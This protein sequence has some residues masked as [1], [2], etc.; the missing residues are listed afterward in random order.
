[1]QD[2]LVSTAVSGG[3]P[4]SASHLQRLIRS[5]NTASAS[6]SFSCCLRHLL[7]CVQYLPSANQH[8]EDIIDPL[9][10]TTI[11][12]RETFHSMSCEEKDV[13]LPEGR[14]GILA[15]R[16]LPCNLQSDV[17]IPRRFTNPYISWAQ[18]NTL[19]NLCSHYLHF[20]VS[21]PCDIISLWKHP[22]VTFHIFARHSFE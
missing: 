16:L 4:P 8:S 19:H 21:R 12:S 17:L 20:S 5:Y 6:A 7:Y 18:T 22:E 10:Q 14:V 11:V 2:L 15:P 9:L 1:M 3:C 13:F